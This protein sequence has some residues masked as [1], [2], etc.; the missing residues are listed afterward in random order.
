MNVGQVIPAVTF[1]A[2]ISRKDCLREAAQKVMDEITR[3]IPERDKEQYPTILDEHFELQV[4]LRTAQG[5]GASLPEPGI[6]HA[7]ALCKM[8]YRPALIHVYAKDLNL[9][10]QALQ[11]P[12]TV[13]EPH[14]IV[15]A[16]EPILA[17]LDQRNPAFLTYRFGATEGNAIEAGLRELLRVARYATESGYTMTMSA[18]RRYRVEGSNSEIVESDPGQAHRW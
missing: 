12:D 9:P 13:R 17:Y 2:G 8:L 3:L 14:Q 6:P 18:T 5:Q 16:V 11:H 15:Q 1:E 7:T 10:V 4:D